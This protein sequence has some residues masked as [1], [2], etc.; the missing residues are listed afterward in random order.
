MT[1]DLGIQAEM[2]FEQGKYGEAY[3]I[4]EQWLAAAAQNTR[5]MTLQRQTQQALQHLKAF[6]ALLAGKSYDEALAAVAQLEKINPRDPGLAEMRKRV[7][8]RMASAKAILSVFRLGRPCKLIL[9]GAVIGAEGELENRSI[10]V[11]RHKLV[12]ENDG[13]KQVGNNLDYTDGQTI[14]FVYDAATMELRPMVETDRALLARRKT[15]EQVVTYEVEHRHVFGKCTGTLVISGLKVE[16]RASEKSHSFQKA[17][18]SL[19]LTAKAGDD[20]VE[21]Q[22][23]EGGQ[24]TSS[25]TFK[26]RNAA[27]AAEI[28]ELWDRLQKLAK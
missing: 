15:L 6:E 23:T 12:I 21:V 17:L 1:E 9:D 14:A 26:V 27:Q 25:W 22:S 18:S 11:G 20:K 13:G 2:L 3:K 8:E 16:Y 19:K 24:G 7:E 28:K 4:A 10:S 5:A